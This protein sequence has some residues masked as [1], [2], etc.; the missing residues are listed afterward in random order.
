MNRTDGIRMT[1]EISP[2]DR[3]CPVC[4]E[5]RVTTFDHPHTFEYG[6]GDSAVTLQVNLP[7]H[8]CQ[9]CDFE[10]LDQDGER[11]K[12]EAVCRHLG[13]LTPGEIR[14]IRE[15]YRMTRLS[16]SKITG[17]GEAT[18]N[19]WENGVL[20][21]NRAND[22]YLR[23]LAM[24]DIFDRLSHLPDRPFPS[25]ECDFEA[26]SIRHDFSKAA[27]PITKRPPTALAGVHLKSYGGWDSS[28]MST[29]SK[30]MTLL[31]Q[32]FPRKTVK[33]IPIPPKVERRAANDRDHAKPKPPIRSIVS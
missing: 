2:G 6:S 27:V 9:A 22:L 23:L 18:L 31:S 5:D 3:T 25:Q 15:Q 17:L 20:L 13:V 10:F 11:I 8:Q 19:R 30:Q 12:H 33:G 32:V 14:R 4:G 28:D 29:A 7:V 1:S 26:R 24:S 21:Q 16:F